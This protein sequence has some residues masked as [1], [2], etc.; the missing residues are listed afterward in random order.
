MDARR[1]RDPGARGSL[2]PEIGGVRTHAERV[3]GVGQ[4]TG[5]LGQVSP[6]GGLRDQHP[7]LRLAASRGPARVGRQPETAR[8]L[9]CPSERRAVGLHDRVEGCEAGLFAAAARADRNIFNASWMP[10]APRSRLDRSVLDGAGGPL[11]RFLAQVPRHPEPGAEAALIL[12]EV[13]E[14]LGLCEPGAVEA[15]ASGAGL[16]LEQV[17]AV[18]AS[19]RRSRSSIGLPPRS[20][21]RRARSQV[22]PS[23]PL[24]TPRR[25]RRGSPESAEA[26]P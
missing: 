3:G 14:R 24:S 6:G 5:C 21:G 17:H 11:G 26:R 23:L 10:E 12:S 8:R 13:T 25:A 2:D 4:S 7:R 20:S 1:H 22:R 16:H 9:L 18:A 19:R 15:L